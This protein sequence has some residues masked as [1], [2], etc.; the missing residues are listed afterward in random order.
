MCGCKLTVKFCGGWKK[1]DSWSGSCK[2]TVGRE[3]PDSWRGRW[4]LTVW[5]CTARENPVSWRD[6]CSVVVAGIN[7]AATLILFNSILLKTQRKI[8][9]YDVFPW[10]SCLRFFCCTKIVFAKTSW[11]QGKNFKPIFNELE[12]IS[13]KKTV[14]SSGEIKKKLWITLQFKESMVG[15]LSIKVIGDMADRIVEIFWIEK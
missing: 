4:R 5:W 12:I 6:R 10:N 2:L 15:N 9:V 1:T 11:V 7:L 8:W 3:K 14:L 13:E